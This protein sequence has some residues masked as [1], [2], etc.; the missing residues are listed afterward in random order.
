MQC[1]QERV[2]SSVSV[3]PVCWLWLVAWFSVIECLRLLELPQYKRILLQGRHGMDRAGLGS[4]MPQKAVSAVL[5]PLP[6]WGL[7]VTG[8][9]VPCAL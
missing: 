9:H 6:C 5:L 3:L 8:L 4:E 1:F 2:F 7:Y